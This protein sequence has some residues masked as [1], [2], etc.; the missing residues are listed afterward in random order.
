MKLWVPLLA[1]LWP[2]SAEARFDL[3]SVEPE[4]GLT[5]PPQE[6]SL[7]LSIFVVIPGVTDLDFTIHE[8]KKFFHIEGVSK[9][10][11]GVMI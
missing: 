8:L 1:T 10:Y 11:R 4:P 6:H 3:A 2:K 7:T 9:P 5:C